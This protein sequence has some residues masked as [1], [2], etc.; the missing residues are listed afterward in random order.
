[1]EYSTFTP[2]N[3]EGVAG[4]MHDYMYRYNRLRLLKRQ[5]RNYKHNKGKKMVMISISKSIK[6]K[7]GKL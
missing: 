1:M 4:V 5:K 2:S 7:G 6:N 3:G